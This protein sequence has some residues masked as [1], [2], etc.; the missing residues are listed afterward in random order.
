MA[1]VRGKGNLEFLIGMVSSYENRLLR[2][3]QLELLSELK[4]LDELD[5][6]ISGSVFHS[7]F[8]DFLNRGQVEILYLNLGAFVRQFMILEPPLVMLAFLASVAEAYK[9]L[10]LNPDITDDRLFGCGLYA[11]ELRLKDNL[12][13]PE[14]I[15]LKQWLVHFKEAAF[16]SGS[17]SELEQRVFA[18]GRKASMDIA[19]LYG[20]PLKDFI[21][22]INLVED[23]GFMVAVLKFRQK[24]KAEIPEFLEAM[25]FSL[26]NFLLKEY[27]SE[28][29]I[30]AGLV[31]LKYQRPA[32]YNYLKF[33]WRAENLSDLYRRVEELK[34]KLY[35]KA[36]T[37]GVTP[38][39]PFVYFQLFSSQFKKIVDAYVKLNL[40]NVK[41]VA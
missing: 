30:F 8:K 34:E 10:W 21:K 23:C 17:S 3:D 26:K 41:E 25:E 13:A 7:L 28:D 22:K 11:F 4:D 37:D 19:A 12:M 38:L 14:F 40:N 39:Y 29:E 15:M 24:V 31:S 9:L 32:F 5:G 16:N 2:P 35:L 1:K 20:E 18:A 36:K 27:E 6:L 33:I